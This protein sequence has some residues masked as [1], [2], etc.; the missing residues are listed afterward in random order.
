MY[1]Y[2]VA[3]AEK[4][5][6]VSL[7]RL[8]YLEAP[9]DDKNVFYSTHITGEQINLLIKDIRDYDELLKSGN[10]VSR[11]CNYNSYG[12]NTECEY[13]KMAKIYSEI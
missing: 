8:F 3:G 13:C 6:T 10:W 5:K 7:S 1:S 9:K 4:G 2:L 12:K 11:P